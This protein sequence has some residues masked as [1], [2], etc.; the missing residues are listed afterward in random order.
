MLALNYHNLMLLTQFALKAKPLIGVVKVSEMLNNELYTLDI[1]IKATVTGELELIELS[2]KISH[3]CRLGFN[4][5]NAI[6]SYIY[7]INDINSNVDFVF[8]SK[9]LLARFAKHL[10]GIKI[11]KASY[12]LAV[13]GFLLIV[14][15]EDRTF[16]IN[17]T[18]KFY[19]YWKASNRLV[20]ES[21]Q[22]NIHVMAQK[23]ALTLLW[24]NIDAQFFSN[25]EICQLTQYTD[26]LVVKGL[27]E[28]DIVLSSKIAKVIM[29]ELR[30]EKATS[31]DTY[32][33]AINR[34]QVQ[35][36]GEELEK[37]F[38]IVSREFYHSWVGNTPKILSVM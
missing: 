36:K 34:T 15:K 22:K 21:E 14:E 38:L 24:Y 37:L 27:T 5:I 28:K 23:K 32:R 30:H 4:L 13:E 3:E 29:I 9:S 17:M 26:S 33:D 7:N 31:D 11:N 35:F 18:R 25:L 1:L 2:R 20:D 10:H 19:R 16:S 8:K 6:A 12:R